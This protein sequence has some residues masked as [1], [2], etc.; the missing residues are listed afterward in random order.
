MLTF[1]RAPRR[2]KTQF[3]HVRLLTCAR[4]RHLS[5]CKQ[6]T[7]FSVQRICY[8]SNDCI[9]HKKPEVMNPK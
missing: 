9:A 8:I 6:N 2:H 5:A 3:A 1:I 7:T 4:A